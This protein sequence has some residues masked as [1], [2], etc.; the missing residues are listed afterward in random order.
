MNSPAAIN[1]HVRAT[2]ARALRFHAALSALVAAGCVAWSAGFAGAIGT[3][4]PGLVGG[5][6]GPLLGGLAVGAGLGAA[7]LA[8]LAWAARRLV[9]TNPPSRA[10]A[11]VLLS[12]KLML[13]CTVI[14]AVLFWLQPAPVGLV[15]GWTTALLALGLAVVPRPAVPGAP[16]AAWLAG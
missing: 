5:P 11:Q 12:L 6:A 4:S 14:A 10:L 15:L 3:G 2:L 8:V 16:P 7:N 13:T 9:G 1:D